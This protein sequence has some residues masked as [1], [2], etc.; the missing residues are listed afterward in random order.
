M[1]RPALSEEAPPA[2]IRPPVESRAGAISVPVWRSLAILVLGIG[3]WLFYWLKPTPN[4]SP[5]SGVVMHLPGFV[6]VGSGF[7]GQAGEESTAEKSILPPD[8]GFLRKIYR[9]YSGPTQV[10]CTIVLSGALQQSIHRPEVCLLGQGF[11]ITDQEDIPIRLKSGH[12]L[13]VRNLT[14]KRATTFQGRAIQSTA[15]NMYWFVGEKI[16]TPSHVTRVFLTSWDR[17]FHNRA[18]RWAYVTV[19]AS[20]MRDFVPDGLDAAQ[21]QALLVNFIREIV[22]SFQKSEMD[23]DTLTP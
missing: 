7:I 15:L 18:H 16:T 6:S 1:T 12:E 4:L 20:V 5:Q 2:P 3:V 8:T 19:N 11:N 17:I 10:A 14:I 13:T 21:T 23:P 9:D 22:P